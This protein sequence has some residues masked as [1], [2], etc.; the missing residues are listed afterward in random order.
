VENRRKFINPSRLLLLT[1]GFGCLGWLLLNARPQQAYAQHPTL[2]IP[3]V[4]GTPSGSIATV[5]S[6]LMQIPVRSGPGQNFPEIGI[7]IQNQRVPALGISPG[8]DW[9][10]IVYIGVPEGVGWIW[11]NFVMISQPL[12]QV[13]LPHTPTPRVT[14]TLNPTL[15]AQFPQDIDPTRMPTFTSAPP[16]IAPTYAAVEP[17]FVLLSN[18][19]IGFIIIGLGVLG[20]FGIFLT[21]LRGR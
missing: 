5:Y 11:G 20:V 4:T 18:L 13:A 7:L 17:S 6:N 21:L 2:S 3:T 10:K 16:I 14:A 15:A 12:D 8:G 9:V 19:P 1:L